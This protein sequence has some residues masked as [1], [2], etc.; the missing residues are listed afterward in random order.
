M[1]RERER[2]VAD[3][4]ARAAFQVAKPTDAASAAARRVAS[5]ATPRRVQLALRHR[6]RRHQQGHQRPDG[7]AQRPEHLPEASTAST[8]KA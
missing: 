8:R 5:A 7:P 3:A 4:A 2:D 6:H 1:D